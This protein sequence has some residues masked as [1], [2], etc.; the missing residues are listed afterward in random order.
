LELNASAE[1]DG[2]HDH[3]AS[4]AGRDEEGQHEVGDDQA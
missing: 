2:G 1:R 4:N 3:D